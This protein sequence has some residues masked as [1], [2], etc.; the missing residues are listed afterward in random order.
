M[1]SHSP[2]L[3]GVISDTHGLLR[4]ES[5]TALRGVDHILHAG[6]VA[7]PLSSTRCAPSHPS[8]PFAATLTALA[9]ARA[10]PP[11]S[12]LNWEGNI[13][14]CFTIYPRWTSIQPP[15]ASLL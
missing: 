4:P 3:I 5:V 7:I 14:I 15:L 13:S 1:N 11:L 2:I 6:D 9:S 10:C 8:Q 12:L